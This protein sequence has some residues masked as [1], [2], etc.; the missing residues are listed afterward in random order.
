MSIVIAVL[1]GSL[2]ACLLWLL[3]Q[4]IAARVRRLRAEAWLVLV[5]WLCALTGAVLA[6]VMKA[7]A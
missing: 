1:I 5:I 2:I 4:V 3:V 6:L 7:L